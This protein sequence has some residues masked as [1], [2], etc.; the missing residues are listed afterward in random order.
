MKT[1]IVIWATA[2]IVA[3]AGLVY[4]DLSVNA[5]VKQ[6]KTEIQASNVQVQP[7]SGFMR[8]SDVCLQTCTASNL[9]R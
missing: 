1:V 4:M 7:A 3:I 5:L 9:Q 6:A 2:G 8:T